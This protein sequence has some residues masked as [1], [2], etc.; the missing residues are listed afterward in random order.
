[1]RQI[2]ELELDTC[3]GMMDEICSAWEFN[4]L[5]SRIIFLLE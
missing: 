5:L 3:I 2:K 4:M 1:M